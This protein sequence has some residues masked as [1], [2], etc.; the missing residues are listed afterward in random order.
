M[1]RRITTPT[2]L[3]VGGSDTDGITENQAAF[4]QMA[5]R[6]ELVLVDGANHLFDDVMSADEIAQLAAGWFARHLAGETVDVGPTAGA[7]ES[8]EAVSL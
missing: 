2:M 4:R 6:K 3:I 1:L 5:G 8:A 7:G